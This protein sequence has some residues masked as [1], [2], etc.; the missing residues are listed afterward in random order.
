MGLKVGTLEAELLLEIAGFVRNSAKAEKQAVKT[1]K[2]IAAASKI[3]KAGAFTILGGVA[4]LAAGVVKSVKLAAGETGS[5]NLQFNDLAM[6][7]GQELLPIATDLVAMLNEIIKN[8]LSDEKAFRSLIRKGI[9][10]A[11][12]AFA[13]LVQ[14]GFEVA[15]IFQR[16]KQ[17][18]QV[19]KI[20]L[21]GSLLA[22]VGSFELM[23]D[24]M[25]APF[26]LMPKLAKR[27]G[28]DADSISEKLKG[29]KDALAAMGK[30][31]KEAF[32]D[33]QKDIKKT[34]LIQ[35]D[36]NTTLADQKLAWELDAKAAQDTA[37]VIGD[38]IPNA[39]G[40][41]D[42]SIKELA[43]STAIRAFRRSITEL[44]KE[45]QAA[46]DPISQTFEELQ[47]SAANAEAELPGVVAQLVAMN[48]AAKTLSKDGLAPTKQDFE[49]IK[50]KV[51]ELLGVIQDADEAA[52]AM[53]EASA[54]NIRSIFDSVAGQITD[55]ITDAFFIA[56]NEGQNA[57]D[58]INK[59]FE[60]LGES[61]LRTLTQKFLE[62]A[63]A[64]IALAIFGEQGQTTATAAGAAARE[65]IRAAET[66]AKIAGDAIAIGSHVAAETGQTA[67][68]VAGAGTR[69]GA[70]AAEGA[71]AA[72]KS[73]VAS[74]IPFPL[75]IAAG[76]GAAALIFGSLI[77]FK[78]KFAKGGIV[79]GPGGID[80]VPAM[81]T[82]GEMVIPVDAT[83]QILKAAR[84]PRVSAGPLPFANG[85]V[86]PGMSG[87]G[88]GITQIFQTNVST[89]GLASRATN[90]RWMRDVFEKNARRAARRKGA[91]PR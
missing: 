29:P 19:M 37:G 62:A 81:L 78:S 80:N 34:R 46:R 71:A 32:N 79:G 24:A 41:A 22:I 66:G 58:A 1:A 11:I 54:E 36:F 48:E 28:I 69:I 42:K 65:A 56:I 53:A 45:I 27:L 52:L 82:K 10:I 83:R 57:V 31:G 73:G 70:S 75:N 49:D 87:G 23:L 59:L 61:L 14:M 15:V 3:L 16:I 40:D 86:V 72:G 33:I 91:G 74:G 85:G 35:E 67:A 2:S 12:D 18:G 25:L 26:R 4:L 39:V 47:Q 76:L 38:D 64:Q 60:Q 51:E 20:G 43:K 88:A 6:V 68:T 44:L 13:F 55:A 8:V 5:L 21:A 50:L 89:F 90:D 17:V 77:A 30:S 9:N 7:I 84:M 63:T